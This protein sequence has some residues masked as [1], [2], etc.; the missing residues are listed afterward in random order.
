MAHKPLIVAVVGLAG[1]GKSEAVLRFIARG[2][3]RVGFN[4]RLYE[5]LERR[6]LK[7]TQECEKAVRDEMRKESGMAVMAERSLPMIEEALQKGVPVVVESL[8]SWSECKLMK[9]RFGDVFRVLAVYAPQHIRY[10]RLGMRQERPL[11]LKEA[12]ARDYAEI[13]NIEKAGAIAIADW[14]VQNTGTKEELAGQVN[15]VVDSLLS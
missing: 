8:Y 7:Q 1:S 2:F 4:D 13:E 14:T 10:E 6:G 5:E 3:F 11:T 15:Q 9:E 12:Q